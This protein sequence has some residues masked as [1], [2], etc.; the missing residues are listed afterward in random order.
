MA[1]KI[2]VLANDGGSWTVLVVKGRR[3]LWRAV[4]ASLKGLR[5]E[6][7]LAARRRRRA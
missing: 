3:T 4:A 7:D 5:R 6:L 1:A 2:K